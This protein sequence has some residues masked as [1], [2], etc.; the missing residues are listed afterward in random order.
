MLGRFPS[1]CSSLGEGARIHFYLYLEALFH[2]VRLKVQS[3]IAASDIKTYE[4]LAIEWHQYLDEE[5]ARY[6]RS[7]YDDVTR[8]WRQTSYEVRV[9]DFFCHRII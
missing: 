5:G 6:R 9:P 7:L 3:L 4:S 2:V 8:R 1:S